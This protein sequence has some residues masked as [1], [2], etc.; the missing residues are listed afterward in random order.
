MLASLSMSSKCVCLVA[1]SKFLFVL[2]TFSC[3]TCDFSSVKLR[4][5]GLGKLACLDLCPFVTA[6]VIWLF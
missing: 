6:R 4:A 1:G 3:P 2:C 5:L